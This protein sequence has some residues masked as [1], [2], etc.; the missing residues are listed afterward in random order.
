MWKPWTEVRAYMVLMWI[1]V[2][3]LLAMGSR[4]VVRVGGRSLLLFPDRFHLQHRG[5]EVSSRDGRWARE[6][7]ELQDCMP[8]ERSWH[9]DLR[10]EG[11]QPERERREG[12]G[13]SVACS[14]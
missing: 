1:A 12:L 14:C 7:Q 8:L 10:L 6:L 3:T 2:Q 13:T 5:A 11:L 9:C 4:T